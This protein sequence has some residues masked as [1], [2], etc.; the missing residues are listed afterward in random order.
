MG[1]NANRHGERKRVRE[2][3]NKARKEI[4]SD[5]RHTFDQQ[6]IDDEI[7]PRPTPAVRQRKKP[8]RKWCRRKEGLEHDPVLVS[9]MK[10]YFGT[11]QM[12]ACSRCG[13]KTHRRK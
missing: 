9:E 11:W 5:K 1:S 8:S 7:D 2:W 13:H 3:G 4:A 12:Y 10:T 6:A